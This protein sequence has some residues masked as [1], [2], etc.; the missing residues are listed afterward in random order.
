M[1]KNLV[2]GETFS[3]ECRIKSIYTI[4][5]T[6]LHNFVKNVVLRKF[7]V[8]QEPTRILMKKIQDQN[9]SIYF[10]RLFFHRENNQI[11][12]FCLNQSIRFCNLKQQK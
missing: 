3:E 1:L 7:E 4:F 9:I 5:W 2:H 10:F 8:F 6:Q 12:F 11:L